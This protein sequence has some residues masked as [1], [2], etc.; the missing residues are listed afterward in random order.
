M[1]SPPIH[2][3]RIVRSIGDELE[4]IATEMAGYRDLP[5]GRHDEK[6]M[7]GP[8]VRAAFEKFVRVEQ[9]LRAMLEK[10]VEPDRSMLAAMGG[11]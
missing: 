7:S 4:A 5:M 10:R 6:A 9:E 3:Q 1:S 2:L 11:R 8:Q